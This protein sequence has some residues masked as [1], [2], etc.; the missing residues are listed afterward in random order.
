VEIICIFD[1]G[2]P[3]YLDVIENTVDV[4]ALKTPDGSVGEVLVTDGSG[5]L[6][7]SDSLENVKILA[8][9]GL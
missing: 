5:N 7:F 2:V 4:A 8:L 1:I 9:V 3:T 6:S